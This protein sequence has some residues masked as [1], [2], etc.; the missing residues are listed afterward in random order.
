MPFP[1]EHV[2]AHQCTL[3]QEKGGKHCAF[4]SYLELL[5]PLFDQKLNVTNQCSDAPVGCNCTI[6]TCPL[7]DGI[8]FSLSSIVNDCI[9]F[10]L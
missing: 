1:N 9:P 7:E 5:V 6:P 4:K 10:N 2:G 8:T 3:V